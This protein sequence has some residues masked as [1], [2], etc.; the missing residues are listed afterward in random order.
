MVYIPTLED[1]EWTRNAIIG[2]KIWAM[3]SGQCVFIMDHSSKVF[4]TGIIMNPTPQN[5]ENYS[6]VRINLLCLGFQEE[7]ASILQGMNTLDEIVANIPMS[8]D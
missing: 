6:R 3:P 2:K 4:R 8:W 7:S 1:I 5:M